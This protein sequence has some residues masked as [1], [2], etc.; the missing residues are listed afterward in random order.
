MTTQPKWTDERTEAL[1][2]FVGDES[3]VTLATVVEFSEAQGGSTRSV[4]SKLRKMGFEVEKV[5]DVARS[6]AF[7]E[8]QATTLAAFVTDNSGTYT[9][10]DIAEHFA[11]GE[12]SPRSIQGKILSMELTDHVKAAPKREYA[13]TYT[14]AETDTIVALAKD[15][16]FLEEIAAE[17]DRPLNSI[18]GKALS[19]D[20]AGLIDGIPPQRDTAPKAGDAF[21]GLDVVT[22]SVAEIAEKTGKT[23][24]GVK[25]MLTRRGLT[26]TDYDGAAKAAKRA[27]VDA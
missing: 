25:T 18:R 2:K 12:F 23:E 11:N 9:Y 1:V 16:K 13:R 27:A 15:G 8:D 17:L 20:R 4:S 5:S 7:T 6:K 19:L 10:A 3:P 21:E 22:L 26:A 14:E 24:R